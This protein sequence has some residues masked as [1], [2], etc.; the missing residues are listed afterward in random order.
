LTLFVKQR[1]INNEEEM[2]ESTLTI[3]G[4]ILAEICFFTKVQ[5]GVSAPNDGAIGDE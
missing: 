3:T 2:G 1:R 5:E 4:G